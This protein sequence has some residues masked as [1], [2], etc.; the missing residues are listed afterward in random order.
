MSSLTTTQSCLAVDCGRAPLPQPLPARSYEGLDG[1]AHDY[2]SLLRLLLDQLARSAPDWTERSGADLAQVLVELAAYAGDQLSYLQDRVA[3]EG[4][5]RTATQRE[6]VRRHL[7]LVDAALDPGFCAQADLLW[8]CSGAFPLFLPRGFAVSTAAHDN[9][10]AVIFETAHDAVLYPALSSIALALDAPSSADGL[11]AV[12]AAQLDGVLSA[13][14]WLLFE[15][16]TTHHWAQV[17]SVAFGAG[18]STVTFMAPLPTS[19]NALAT[20]VQG[21]RVRATHGLTQHQDEIGSGSAA[22]RIALTHAP[23]IWVWD[24]SAQRARSTLNLTVDGLDWI[25]VEDFLDVSAAARVYAVSSDNAGYVTVHF[26][27]GAQGAVPALGSRIRITYRIGDASVKPQLNGRVGAGTL[28]E[29]NRQRAFADPSQRLLAVR[30]PMASSAPQAPQDLAQARLLGPT[31]VR[32]PKRAVVAADY[33]A[34]VDQGVLHAGTRVQPLC[35]RARIQHTGSWNTVIVSIDMPGRAPLAAQLGLRAAFET[36]LNEHKMA[37]VDVR[38]E[39]ARYC[40]LHL[41]LRVEVEAAHFAR[42]VCEAIE[43]A[44]LSAQDALLRPGRLR[45]GMPLHL[46]DVYAAAQGVPG[47]RTVA[48]TRFKRLGDRYPDCEAQGYIDVGALEIARC[49]N[50]AAHPEHGV[51]RVQVCGGRQ[52]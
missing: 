11:Q 42:D 41:G 28:T 21:N 46:S 7:R 37:G 35:S 24:E 20:Q 47:V 15:Q 32:Q 13:G 12:L 38:V 19:F 44:L 36:V 10:N 2:D 33:E 49:D 51:L 3:L 39:D 40:P 18:T 50:D 30:N 26:G 23:L 8:S 45:F 48:V 1:A 6:S 29:F 31:T 17:A 5:L 4:F 9:E 25:E 22:Q 34:L 16:G 14:Q 43:H 27:D 52:G